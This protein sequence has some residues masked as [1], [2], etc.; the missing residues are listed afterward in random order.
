M[1]GGGDVEGDHGCGTQV[2]SCSAKW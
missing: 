2:K 1:D